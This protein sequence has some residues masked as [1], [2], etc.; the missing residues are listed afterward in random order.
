M[1]DS[2]NAVKQKLLQKTLEDSGLSSSPGP[3]IH[4]F[5]LPSMAFLGE[6]EISCLWISVPEAGKEGTLCWLRELQAVDLL[7]LHH[8]GLS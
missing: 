7:T 1:S 8:T 5:I 2:P 6:L 4:L 3:L